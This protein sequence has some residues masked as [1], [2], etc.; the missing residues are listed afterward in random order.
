MATV[1]LYQPSPAAFAE[2]ACA[3]IVEACGI[4]GV[5]SEAKMDRRGVLHV[6]GSFAVGERQES[7]LRIE[8]AS[9]GKSAKISSLLDAWTVELT[10]EGAK[11]SS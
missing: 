9:D 7:F 6:E 5:V 8:V 1:A 2:F 3:L 10:T 4:E 11:A